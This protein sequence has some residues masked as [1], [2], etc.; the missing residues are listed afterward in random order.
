[1]DET[2]VHIP[3]M[4][5]AMRPDADAVEEMFT[6]ENFESPVQTFPTPPN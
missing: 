2:L 5:F 1:M 6:E 4:T 3:V